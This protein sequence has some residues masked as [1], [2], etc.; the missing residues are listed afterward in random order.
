MVGYDVQT[1]V[2]ATSHLIVAH[3]LT[4]PGLCYLRNQKA[5]HIREAGPPD[6]ALGA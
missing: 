1:A 3:E 2:D 6:K 4:N 5:M